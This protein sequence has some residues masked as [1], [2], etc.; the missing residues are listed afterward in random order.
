MHDDLPSD[1]F[2]MPVS[3]HFYPR[4]RV[5]LARAFVNEERHRLTQWRWPRRL[6]V[7]LAAVSK[8]DFAARFRKLV[9]RACEQGGVFHI[10][11]HS[12]EID[13]FNG[14]ALL[15]TVLRYAAERVPAAARVSNQELALAVEP[16][17]RLRPEL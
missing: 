6:P 14:W 13:R 11:G 17:G 7:F 16:T 5:D 1:L 12:W 4:R 3:L 15:D 8:D 10:W 2:Q 9:D